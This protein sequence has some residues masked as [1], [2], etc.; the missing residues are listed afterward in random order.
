MLQARLTCRTNTL[1]IDDLGLVLTKGD[2]VYISRDKAASSPE[3]ATAQRAGAVVVS[4]VQVGGDT[5]TPVVSVSASSRQRHPTSIPS[6]KVPV[7]TPPKNEAQPLKGT[8]PLTADVEALVN[9]MSAELEESKVSSKKPSKKG[10]SN[11]T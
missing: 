6:V 3:L 7:Q 10:A 5:R 4:I 11:A 9:Q 1:R 2:V 8:D